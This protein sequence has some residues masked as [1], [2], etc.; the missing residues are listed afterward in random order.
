I[1]PGD[2]VVTFDGKDVKDPKDLSRV[3]ADTAVGKEVDV[4]VIR[5][6]QEETKKVTLGRLQ[7]P[8]QVQAA[9]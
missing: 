7:D 5:K 6:G 9:V 8:D 2:V 1:E 4:I 3:G